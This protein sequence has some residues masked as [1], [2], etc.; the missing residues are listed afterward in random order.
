MKVTIENFRCFGEKDSPAERTFS[1][2]NVNLFSGVSGR[3]KT[4]TF[5]A[6][7]WCLF[8]RARGIK[9]IDQGE[10]SE[11]VETIDPIERLPGAKKGRTKACCPPKTRVT[12]ELDGL[13]VMR[14]KT[15]EVFQIEENSVI[16]EGKIAQ[17]R[18]F[19]IFG[20]EDFFIATSFLQQ[21]GEHPLVYLP[22][23]ERFTL[24]Y[25][26]TF[27]YSPEEKLTPDSYISTVSSEINSRS[28][29]L[30]SLESVRDY[31][32]KA[33]YSQEEEA[34]KLEKKFEGLDTHKQ[35]KEREMKYLE[36]IESVAKDIQVL[37]K[38]KLEHFL[39]KDRI[40]AL[41]S[42][43][44]D[45]QER[46]DSAK[47]VLKSTKH[48]DAGQIEKTINDIS[49]QNKILE[50][51]NK[52]EKVSVDDDLN[53]LSSERL[54]ELS[55]LCANVCHF[56]KPRSLKTKTLA[57]ERAKE[58]IEAGKL[59]SELEEQEESNRQKFRETCLQIERQNAE[60]DLEILKVKSQN[61]KKK[62]V[63]KNLEDF[64]ANQEAI[65]A[66]AV[67]LE[68]L[69]KTKTELKD[70]LVLVGIKNFISGKEIEKRINDISRTLDCLEC[71]ECNVSLAVKDRKLVKVLTAEE[72]EALNQTKI[73]LEKIH[74]EVTRYE[75]KSL[76]WASSKPKEIAEPELFDLD[77][78]NLD[79]DE[80]PKTAKIEI[81]LYQPLRDLSKIEKPKP[82]EVTAA[83]SFLEDA[84]TVILNKKTLEKL[85]DFER[86]LIEIG[87]IPIKREIETELATLT[88]PEKSLEDLTTLRNR[89]VYE[90]KKYKE[91]SRRE[92]ES[93]ET[94]T[95]I[96]AQLS[97]I[98]LNDFDEK[99]LLEKVREKTETE[100]LLGDI[101]TFI[102]FVKIREE[103]QDHETKINSIREEI[104]VLTDLKKSAEFVSIESVNSRIICLEQTVNSLLGV[105]FEKKPIKVSIKA[106]KEP[107]TKKGTEKN[108]VNM[109][110]LRDGHELKLLSG[111]ESSRFNLALTMAMN[112]ISGSNILL[113]DEV[114]D[115]IE[116]ELKES[117]IE[118]VKNHCA[119]KTVIFICH[120][121]VKGMYDE[122]VMI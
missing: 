103:Y 116:E 71:P 114:L 82:N 26:L 11:K 100:S 70:S 62:L 86:L 56:M 20:D 88:R 19:Q 29:D 9:P 57:V 69:E 93:Q 2:S 25:N 17:D 40:L 73:G 13:F 67:E 117:T 41:E 12:L 76:K 104:K 21:K 32:L 47:E 6:V 34:E 90:D 94:V 4:T 64:Y 68:A 27:G 96:Q 3:G 16:L 95:K 53:D 105:L 15:P 44:D 98:I 61:E 7:L 48:V 119:G 74:K 36:T 5:H 87:N 30:K 112:S 8:G 63:K 1:E 79:C 108:Q 113:L 24:L 45:A 59:A 42:D 37:E 51:E 110:I 91:Y 101:R 121:S 66:H 55:R 97:K 49:T 65:K 118:L 28:N 33:F 31:I 46:L 102:D 85:E 39:A 106:I 83:K 54:S 35:L 78:N 89:L 50:L 81:P 23:A 14:E 60:L 75:L 99:F 58:I 10:S 122:V 22:C 77:K 120:N 92:K 107:K 80:L 84:K 18:I 111:G 43:L 72:R 115:G 38:K 109:T 52:L